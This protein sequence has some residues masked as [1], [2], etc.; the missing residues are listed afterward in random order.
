MSPFAFPYWAG[1]VSWPLVLAIPDRAQFAAGAD[2][3]SSDNPVKAGARFQTSAA[4]CVGAWAGAIALSP[5]FT[6]KLVIGAGLLVL[7]LLWWCLINP[8][9]WLALFFITV[10]L[11]PPLP[12]SFA[13]S[14]PHASIVFVCLG[15][16]TGFLR[17]RRWSGL[18]GGLTIAFGL[19][20]AALLVSIGLASLYSGATVAGAS[21]LRVL[22][23]A[24]GPGVCL[25][26][27]TEGAW[28]D[29]VDSLRTVRLLFGISVVSALFACLDFYFQFPA[30]ARYGPQFVWLSEGV[31]RRAQGLF[32][33]AST[34]GNYCTFFIVM[35]A[36]A[37]FRPRSERPCSTT[38]LLAG[39]A[40]LTAA[41]VFSYS[42]G[43][44]LNLVIAIFT[45]VCL[46]RSKASRGLA[47]LAACAGAAAIIVGLIFPSFA[48]SY[49]TRLV[50]S[51]QYFW[52]SPEGVLSGRVANWAML[53]DFAA[54]EPWNLFFGI[55]YKTL[56][57]SKY[58]GS[59]LIGDN[60]YLTLLVET[61]LIGLSSFLVLNIFILRSALKAVRSKRPRANFL[62]AWI[63]CFWVGELVQMMSGDLITY[64]RVLPIYLWVL[65]TA[66]RENRSDA[67]ERS[68][69]L[70]LK[71]QWQAQ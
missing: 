42:R 25:V 13:N 50:A 32:Y 65:A 51:I 34:L 44:L 24:I 56:P 30:P 40:A 48:Q 58:L 69:R 17:P 2:I 28:I 41:L 52:S 8:Q 16:L 64:W 31:F 43:S 27:L 37:L 33:E 36:V 45:L 68:Y 63:F 53:V 71:S 14:N 21:F 70:E 6:L 38:W 47:I 26:T 29:R 3:L 54:R 11:L 49:W 22:L 18:N 1:F 62:G 12:V 61:G 46:Q 7:P 23:F 19:F 20:I 35:I 59:A 60:T 15:I 39:G 4:V 67:F 5:S 9:L 10:V 55:G 66:I 57:Y